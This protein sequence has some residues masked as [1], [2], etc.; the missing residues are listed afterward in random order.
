MKVPSWVPGDP[1][2]ICDRCGF[3]VRMSQSRKTWDGLRV[4]PE[5]WEPR[6]PQDFVRGR[7]DKQAVYDG[8]PEPA[9]SFLPQPYGVGTFCLISPNGTTY[10]VIVMDDGALP[11][12]AGLIG[13]PETYL[14]IGDWK[15]TVDDDGAIHVTP[16]G[17]HYPVWSMQSQ[18]EIQH[19]VT[20]DIDGALVVT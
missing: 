8:R 16:H 15:L 13:T 18:N 9:D 19:Y 14:P 17:P 3:A 5:D 7:I 12:F 2:I 20:P 6:Q 10:I 11:V 4:C 1:W